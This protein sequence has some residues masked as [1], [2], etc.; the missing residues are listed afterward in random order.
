MTM[1]KIDSQMSKLSDE[2]FLFSSSC[3]VGKGDFLAQLGKEK[4]SDKRRLELE[5]IRETGCWLTNTN[6]VP[7][8]N[9]LNGK[10]LLA[11]EF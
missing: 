10:F 4:P 2:Y 3:S 1:A 5:R 8:P 9:R 6:V 7:V 11:E